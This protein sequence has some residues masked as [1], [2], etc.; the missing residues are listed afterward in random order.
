MTG[1][2]IIPTITLGVPGEAAAAVLMGGLMIHG[3]RPGPLLFTEQADIVYGILMAFFL[4]N[5]FMMVFQFIGIKLFVKVL[6]VPRSFLIP[7]ILLFC[8]IGSFGVSGNLFD[9]YLLLVFGVLGFFLNKYGYGTAPVVL[10]M[11]LGTM[12]ETEFRKGLIMFEG[13]G[14]VFFTRPISALFL[15]L[16]LISVLIPLYQKWRDSRAKPAA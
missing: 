11:I 9:V 15:G 10:G 13:D 14:T 2:A 12:A 1:G 4:A 16:A 5:I 7:V 8:V 3:L 6:G